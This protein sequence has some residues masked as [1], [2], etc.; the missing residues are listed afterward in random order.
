[1]SGVAGHRNYLEEEEKGRGHKFLGL[2]CDL[3]HGDFF[4]ASQT[5]LL[6]QSTVIPHRRLQPLSGSCSFLGF[7]F[8]SNKTELGVMWTQPGCH[9]PKQRQH[10]DASKTLTLPDAGVLHAFC[11]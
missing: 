7:Q 4:R 3:V 10:M 8:W 6:G 5:G 1:V 2:F 11:Y 9:K